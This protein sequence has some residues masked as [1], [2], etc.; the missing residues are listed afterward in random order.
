[1]GVVMRNSEK[2]VRGAERIEGDRARLG[3]EVL[4]VVLAC[5]RTLEGDTGEV[6]GR[7]DDWADS[8]IVLR[9]PQQEVPEPNQNARSSGGDV[10]GFLCP[11]AQTQTKPGRSRIHVFSSLHRRQHRNERFKISPGHHWYVR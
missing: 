11:I 1:M 3:V 9:T 5:W 2:N 8:E 6:A 10:S 4:V 7:L